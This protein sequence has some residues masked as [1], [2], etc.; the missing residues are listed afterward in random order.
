[1]RLLHQLAMWK[2]EYGVPQPVSLNW[3]VQHPLKG[4]DGG[5]SYRY[6]K[7]GMST[8]EWIDAF[9]DFGEA[10]TEYPIA[11]QKPP[12]LNEVLEISQFYREILSP[13]KGRLETIEEPRARNG[14]RNSSRTEDY[15]ASP[16]AGSVMRIGPGHP[17]RH[18][19]MDK[20]Y[21]PRTGTDR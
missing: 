2:Q 18:G 4:E 16:K 19:F 17:E 13:I 12:V 11:G 3:A 21:I 5:A 6:Y 10:S 8:N 14:S 7:W 9:A 1:M 15:V 20:D